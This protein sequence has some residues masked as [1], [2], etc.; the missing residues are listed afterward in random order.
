MKYPG[1]QTHEQIHAL[2]EQMR[3]AGQTAADEWSQQSC[4]TD[5][6]EF[7]KE[8]VCEIQLFSNSYPINL[9]E[10]CHVLIMIFPLVTLIQKK[11]PDILLN[12]QLEE[13]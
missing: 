6:L 3:A 8:N 9:G 12:L 11:E 2:R 4:P 13:F 5:P 7:E 1:L 10:P